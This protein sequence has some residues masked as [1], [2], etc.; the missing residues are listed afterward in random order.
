MNLLE[1]FLIIFLM[2]CTFQSF[3]SAGERVKVAVQICEHRRLKYF[4]LAVA[5]NLL[6]LEVD[7]HGSW[8]IIFVSLTQDLGDHTSCVWGRHGGARVGGSTSIRGGGDDVHTLWIN[9]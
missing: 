2:M 5:G 4:R 8:G 9:Q 1:Y 7:L 3:K 6:A